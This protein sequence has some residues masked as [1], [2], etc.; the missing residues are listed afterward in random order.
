MKSE[1]M[2]DARGLMGALPV[3]MASDALKGMSSGEALVLMADLESSVLEDLAELE[4]RG[5]CEL[6]SDEAG[7]VGFKGY[8]KK[9]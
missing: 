3:L 6:I 2:R 7:E 5:V 4:T 8:I 9:L 1:V